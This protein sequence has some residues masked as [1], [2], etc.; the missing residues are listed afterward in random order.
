MLQIIVSVVVLAER[1]DEGGFGC[2]QHEHVGFVDRLPAADAGAVEAETVFE[3]VLV[4]R[5]GGDGE[6]LPQAGKIHETQID[7]LDFLFTDQGQN[8]FGCHERRPPGE[9]EK[10]CVIPAARW[11]SHPSAWRHG[12]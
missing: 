12:Q 11:T 1:I 6:M 4:E 3:D 5:L 2:G 9:I 8:F 7:G 10:R